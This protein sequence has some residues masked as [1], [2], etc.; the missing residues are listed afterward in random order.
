MGTFPNIHQY[1]SAMGKINTDGRHSPSTGLTESDK[2]SLA[3]AIST[4]KNGRYS[5]TKSPSSSSEDLRPMRMN[6]KQEG[7]FENLS[8]FNTRIQACIEPTV[9]LATKWDPLCFH[10]LA[11]FVIFCYILSKYKSFAVLQGNISATLAV[12][13]AAETS[14]SF[15]RPYTKKKAGK[16]QRIPREFAEMQTWLTDLSC[17]WQRSPDLC[18]SQSTLPWLGSC[19][20]LISL[21]S[22]SPLLCAVLEHF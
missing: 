8:G 18:T 10:T 16:P 14:Y 22:F 3:S 5:F 21:R 7:D 13:D 11:R 17:A 2:T 9:L 6:L 20:D 4:E 1:L 15:V 19:A 12:D